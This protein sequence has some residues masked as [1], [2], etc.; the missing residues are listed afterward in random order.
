MDDHVFKMERVV[1]AGRCIGG[2]KIIGQRT[3]RLVPI[4]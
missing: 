4:R 1:H 2:G 3:I